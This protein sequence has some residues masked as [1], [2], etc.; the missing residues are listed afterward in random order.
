MQELQDTAPTNE[1]ASFLGVLNKYINNVSITFVLILCNEFMIIFLFL[2]VICNK[3]VDSKDIIELR[4]KSIIV[5]KSFMFDFARYVDYH[6]AMQA[7]NALNA[8]T[9]FSKSLLYIF[10]SSSFQSNHGPITYLYS[11]NY[12]N[13][14]QFNPSNLLPPF[15]GKCYIICIN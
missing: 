8:L 14:E 7:Y 2:Q 13:S 6:R 3:P 9:K 4:N 10:S 11:I 1:L 12:M 15:N 5:M